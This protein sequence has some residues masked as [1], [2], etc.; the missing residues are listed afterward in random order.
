MDL[1]SRY[2]RSS[3]TSRLNETSQSMGLEFYANHYGQRQFWASMNLSASVSVSQISYSS[4]TISISSCS[5]TLS[6]LPPTRRLELRWRCLDLERESLSDNFD[7]LIGSLF[8]GTMNCYWRLLIA[9]FRH[10]L[11]FDYPTRGDPLSLPRLT[12]SGII[13]TSEQ[14]NNDNLDILNVGNSIFV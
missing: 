9:V 8:L 7:E 5:F 12:N 11:K 1:A 13:I 14:G 3:T 10:A 2:T 4:E 6:Y